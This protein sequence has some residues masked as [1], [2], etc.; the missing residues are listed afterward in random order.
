MTMSSVRKLGVPIVLPWV[1][2]VGH[3]PNV[4]QV[5]KIKDVGQNHQVYTKWTLLKCLFFDNH[6]LREACIAL[7]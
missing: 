5:N 7:E 1:A 6:K 2:M 3:L 4:T